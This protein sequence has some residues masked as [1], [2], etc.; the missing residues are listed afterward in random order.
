MDAGALL[1]PF[2]PALRQTGPQ[3]L[4]ADR[5]GRGP[6]DR[7]ALRHRSHGPRLIA[8][9]P[10]GRAQGALGAHHRR[11]ETMVRETALDDLA[12]YTDMI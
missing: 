7:T 2:A 11:V 1:E 8:G 12:D 5:R 6:A 4:V 10:A 9:H 3:Q